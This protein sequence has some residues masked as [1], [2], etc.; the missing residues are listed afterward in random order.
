MIDDQQLTHI[1]FWFMGFL[2]LILSLWVWHIVL[3]EWR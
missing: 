2:Y 1:Q 3:E